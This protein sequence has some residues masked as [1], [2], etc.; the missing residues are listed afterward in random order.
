MVR[1]SNFPIRY[2]FVAVLAIVLVCPV[3]S[4]RGQLCV[5]GLGS[6]CTSSDPS[7]FITNLAGCNTPNFTCYANYTQVHSA[8]YSMY[9]CSGCQAGYTGRTTASTSFVI[10]APGYDGQAG[11]ATINYDI[12]YSGGGQWTG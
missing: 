2:R 3:P 10:S 8:A 6:T 12:I 5:W 11:E 9:R 1:S 7:L 4:A